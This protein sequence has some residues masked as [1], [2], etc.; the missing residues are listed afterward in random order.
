MKI[1]FHT[2]IF[3]DKIAEKTISFLSKKGGIKNFGDGT[4]DGLLKSM[5]K[6]GVDMSVILPV[7]T[8]PEQFTSINKFACRINEQYGGKLISFGGIHPLSENYKAELKEIKENGFQGIKLHPDYQGVFINDIR[9]KRIIYEASALDLIISVH[10]GIDVGYPNEAV[11]CPP[12]RSLEVIREIKPEKLV[13]AHMGG[14]KQWEAVEELLCGENVW[15]DTGFCLE[16]MEE[17]R[18]Y[19]II[20]KHGYDKILFATDNPWSDQSDYVNRMETFI[21]DEK[22]RSAIFGENVKKLLRLK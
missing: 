16:H 12:E 2:H 22:V 19:S 3:P 7:V 17:S 10:A 21:F 13:L 11:K 15:F 5:S 6:S 8:K 18:F 9:F 20:E 1:D 14:W 4:A